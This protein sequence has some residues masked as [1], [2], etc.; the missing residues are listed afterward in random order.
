MDQRNARQS[1]QGQNG[2]TGGTIHGVDL[3]GNYVR[4]ISGGG[5]FTTIVDALGPAVTWAAPGRVHAAEGTRALRTLTFRQRR[6]RMVLLCRADTGR[7]GT[8]AGV[9]PAH[10]DH[11]PPPT[12]WHGLL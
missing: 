3:F 11:E 5:S 12:G 2:I 1:K 9:S 7:D 6:S 4:L 8:K 10:R